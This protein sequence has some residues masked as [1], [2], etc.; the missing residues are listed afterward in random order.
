MKRPALQSKQVRVLRM[1]FRD[2]LETGP[3]SQR[4]YFRVP[5]IAC[6][7]QL[8]ILL[9]RCNRITSS[10]NS[11][12][13]C[14]IKEA[15]DRMHKWRPKRYSFVSSLA[16]LARKEKYNQNEASW[17]NLQKD[18][19]QKN[20]NLAAFFAFGLSSLKIIRKY[21]RMIWRKEL[22]LLSFSYRKGRDL[23]K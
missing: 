17:S 19:R 15:I 1:A 18:K 13:I 7:P 10:M 21:H 12:L 4:W 16:S 14:C 23:E 2:F 9:Q 3:C 22:R 20:I 5:R 6:D 11:K 8:Q